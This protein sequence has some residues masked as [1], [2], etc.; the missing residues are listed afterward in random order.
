MYWGV[1]ICPRLSIGPLTIRLHVCPCLL[2]AVIPRDFVVLAITDAS[3]GAGPLG[4]V[5]AVTDDNVVTVHCTP[6]DTERDYAGMLLQQYSGKVTDN[7]RKRAT[8]H[9]Q[10]I[11]KP[12]EDMAMRVATQTSACGAS[13]VWT[14]VHIFWGY[15]YDSSGVWTFVH[16][17]LWDTF[18]THPRA[19]VWTIVHIF[20]IFS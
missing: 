4:Y 10:R 14:H 5:I 13:E 3:V 12:S 2:G 9:V 16:I 15:F 17:F 20:W 7:A 11:C 6:D 19:G 8:R 18:M 1:D